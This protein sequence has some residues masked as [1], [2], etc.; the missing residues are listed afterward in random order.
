MERYRNSGGDSGV[1]AYEER[2]QGIVLQ[3]ANGGRYLYTY[4]SSGREH[5]VAMKHL[6][7]KGRGLATYLNQHVGGRYAAKLA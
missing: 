1:I 7:R 5:I 3:F 6:A 4:A 2:P